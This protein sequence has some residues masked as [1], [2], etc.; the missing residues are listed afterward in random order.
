MTFSSSEYFGLV[1]HDVEIL[2]TP[3]LPQKQTQ[4][5]KHVLLNKKHVIDNLSTKGGRVVRCARHMWKLLV[6]L[7]D[8]Y[9]VTMKIN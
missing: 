9:E 1:R 8:F 6:E 7:M 5:K 4:K 3:N 2:V